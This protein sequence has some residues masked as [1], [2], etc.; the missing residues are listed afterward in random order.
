MFFFCMQLHYISTCL[1]YIVQCTFH[2]NNVT[3]I[4]TRVAADVFTSSH[5][6]HIHTYIQSQRLA[7]IS[8]NENKMTETFDSFSGRLIV[9]I[10][11]HFTPSSIL[12]H[13]NTYH[14][15]CSH[16]KCSSIEFFFSKH[17]LLIQ[18]ITIIVKTVSEQA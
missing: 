9:P 6:V 16:Q 2:A 13:T 7:V 14:Q 1:H 5:Y 4:Y 17:K 3:I 12:I 8:R 10:T 18:I 15:E 11:Q